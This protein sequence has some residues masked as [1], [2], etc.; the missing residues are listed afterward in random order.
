MRIIVLTVLVFGSFVSPAAA[1][2]ITLDEG[3]ERVGSVVRS[4]VELPGGVP[5][6]VSDLPPVSSTQPGAGSAERE[7]A[8]GLPPQSPRPKSVEP[9][10]AADPV[11][12]TADPGSSRLAPAADTVAGATSPV[13]STNASSGPDR[14]TA[15]AGADPDHRS[16]G[17]AAE[18]GRPEPTPGSVRAAMPAPLR[19]WLAYLW[20]AIALGPLG[21]ALAMEVAALA[22]TRLPGS[23]PTPL[24]LFRAR[25]GAAALGSPEPAM[26]A[27]QAA[28]PNPDLFFLSHSG[29]MSFLVTVI[30]VLAALVGLVA[31][32]RLTVGEDFFS[33]R[34]LR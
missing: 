24:D 22:P 2:S 33:L 16:A 20:P 34:W 4:V 31:L 3:L 7:I 28:R 17:P 8:P 11:T 32:A 15:P 9:S 1:S 21:K 6:P 27:A 30:T 10:G 19:E 26:P 13:D 25:D 23:P 14:D 29:G 12:S 5:P 18:L